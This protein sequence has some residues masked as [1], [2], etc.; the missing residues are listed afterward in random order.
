MTASPMM[1]RTLLAVDEAVEPSR[2]RI[3]VVFGVED[4]PRG[5]VLLKEGQVR[6]VAVNGG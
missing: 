6:V 1:E 3:A 2:E 4:V 5:V